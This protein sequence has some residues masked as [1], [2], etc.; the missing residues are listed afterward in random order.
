M[1]AITAAA[2]GAAIAAGGTIAAGKMS[3]D[4]QKKAAK[5]QMDIAHQAA[6]NFEAINTPQISDQILQLERL[7][8]SGNL[9]PEQESA[10][11]QKESELKSIQV[12]PQLRD[13]QMQALQKLQQIGNEEGLT[14]VDKAQINE[15]FNKVNN[16]NASNR[17]AVLQSYAQRGM[18]GSGLEQAAQ[19]MG[20]QAAS[21]TAADQGFNVAAQA[22]Q[23]A[24]QAIQAGAQLGSGMEQQQF[25]EAAQQAAAQDAIN[26][27]NVANQQDVTGRNVQRSNYAQERNLN[28]DQSIENQNVDIGNK[29]QV[30]NKGLYQQD[31]ANQLQLAQGKANA[32]NKVA[33]AAQAQG[34]A[35]AQAGSAIG[36]AAGGVGTSLL[37]YGLGQIG[38]QPAANVAG[39]SSEYVANSTSNVYDPNKYKLT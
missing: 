23:R 1:A 9:T 6:N 14:A 28:N 24:L 27:F 30:A 37:N 31:F 22:Q 3:A 21:N 39:T 25:G 35:A 11:D 8:S 15:I 29:E 17:N 36:Q 18:A 7:K 20:S 32:L 5:A 4:A 38:K 13:A 33:G 16:L 34:N 2:V 12:N 26:R 10:I 19:L